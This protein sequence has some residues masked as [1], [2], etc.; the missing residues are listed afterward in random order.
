RLFETYPDPYSFE[1]KIPMIVW[2]GAVYKKHREDLLKAGDQLS[3][4]DFGATNRENPKLQQWV[5]PWMTPLEQMRYR[6]IFVIEGNDIASNIQ[7][8]MASNSVCM[9]RKPRFE[10]WFAEGLLQPGVHYIQIADDFSDLEEKF[11]YYAEHIE[12][13]LKIITNANQYVAQFKDLRDQYAL[14]QTVIQKYALLS[15]QATAQR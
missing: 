9:M 5:R 15:G 11:R 14:G 6:F 7:W 4:C 12:E 13:T 3:F 8:A 2:R 1:Q 10:S